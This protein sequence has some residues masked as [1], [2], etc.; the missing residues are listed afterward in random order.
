MGMVDFDSEQ[1]LIKHCIHLM[2]EQDFVENLRSDLETYLVQKIH[3]LA[4]EKAK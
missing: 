2:S 3:H 1:F 4:Q